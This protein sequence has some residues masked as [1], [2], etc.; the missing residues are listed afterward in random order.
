MCG[1]C[2]YVWVYGTIKG[3][4]YFKKHISTVACIITTA[5]VY[6]SY[7][8]VTTHKITSSHALINSSL[9]QSAVINEHHELAKSLLLQ[10]AT[11]FSPGYLGHIANT[12][13]PKNN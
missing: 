3:R 12:A 5:K 10:N 7:K 11:R 13:T 9:A 4:H 8:Q 2:M 1:V 6:L